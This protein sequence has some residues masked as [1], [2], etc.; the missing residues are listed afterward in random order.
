MAARTFSYPFQLLRPEFSKLLSTNEEIEI[1]ELI[2]RLIQTLSSPKIALDDKHTP[3]LYAR[4]LAG[5]LS[6][7]RRESPA[8]QHTTTSSSNSAPP[9]DAPAISV[10]A[11]DETIESVHTQI[12]DVEHLTTSGQS[13]GLFQEASVYTPETAIMCDSV[14]DMNNDFLMEN[15]MLSDEELLATMQILKSPGWWQNMMMP[16]YV[17]GYTWA[18]GSSDIL[19]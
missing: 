14:I 2:S 3:K 11:P 10:Q 6:R 19:Y 13:L 18:T 15:G 16:G 4:F 5:L 9:P 17:F 7:H 1:L 12:H 8:R